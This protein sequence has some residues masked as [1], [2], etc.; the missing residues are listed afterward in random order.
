[1]PE[2]NEP[3]SL[4]LSRTILESDRRHVPPSPMLNK[5]LRK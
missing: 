3:I 1:M 5:R 4:R 2:A